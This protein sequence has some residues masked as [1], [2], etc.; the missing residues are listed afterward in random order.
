M[1]RARKPQNAETAG[2]RVQR[3]VV[4][5]LI[6]FTPETQA[7]RQGDQAAPADKAGA[8]KY[9]LT[10]RHISGQSTACLAHPSGRSDTTTKLTRRRKPERRSEARAKE[11]RL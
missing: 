5:L 10:T 1:T 9:R 11:R 6:R 3:L 8:A 7:P 2:G 4:L